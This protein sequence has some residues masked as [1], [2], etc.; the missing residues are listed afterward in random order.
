ML[1]CPWDF[2][3]KNTGVG[4]HFLLQ[5]IF[6][7]KLSSNKIECL[8]GSWAPYQEVFK[9]K[10]TKIQWQI[11]E[12]DWVSWMVD[13]DISNCTAGRSHHVSA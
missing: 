5:G 2:P 7:V 12:G 9:Q 4:C 11:A 6:Q 13:L 8:R 3:D 1:L 10:D